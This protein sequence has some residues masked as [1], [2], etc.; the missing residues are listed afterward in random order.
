[1]TTQFFT[2]SYNALHFFES[3]VFVEICNSAKVFREHRFNVKL[4][5]SDFTADNALKSS[6][7]GEFI[8]VQ[9]V[10]DCFYE[11]N[12][13]S[14]TLVDYKTDYIPRGMPTAE[15]EKMLLDR[16]RLQLGYYSKALALIT[17]K[18]IARTIV[19]SFGLG[20]AIEI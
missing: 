5:A 15:A 6:L 7:L 11:N 10:M 17:K 14:F 20:R 12:D 3:E 9:G 2:L 4:P 13:G 1:M 18:P 19:Y 16:H 8:L